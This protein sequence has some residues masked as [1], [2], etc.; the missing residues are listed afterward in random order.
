MRSWRETCEQSLR[1]FTGADAQRFWQRSHAT[2][3]A[4][5]APFDYRFEHTLAVVKLARWLAPQIG[6]DLEATECAAWLHDCRKRLK[7]PQERDHHAQEASAAVPEILAGTDFPSAKIPLVQVAIERHVGL[8]L[9]RILEPV[10]AACLWDADKL[11][12]L[13]AASVVHFM[14]ISPAFQPVTTSD[15]LARGLRWLELASGIVESMN[16]EPARE[17]ARRR[18]V[19]LERHYLQLAREWADPMEGVPG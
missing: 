16:T 19:F 10:E 17:E 14:G 15:V 2:G 12:K 13:G 8:R 18:Y 1:A 6:A 7:E 11:S 9:T 3:S 5:E 4:P